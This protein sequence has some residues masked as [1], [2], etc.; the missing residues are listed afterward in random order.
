MLDVERGYYEE[1]KAILLDHYK[2]KF[3]LIQGKELFGTFDT[4]EQAYAEGIRLFGTEPFLARQVAEEAAV[5][6]YPALTLGL[7]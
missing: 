3:A 4:G 7:L 2:G 5:A 6:K 1:I